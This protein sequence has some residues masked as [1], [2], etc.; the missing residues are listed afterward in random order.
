[1]AQYLIQ[2]ALWWVETANLDGIRLD[3]F[4]YVSRAYWQNFHAAL[5]SVYPHLTT[6]GEVFHR[7]PEVTS[8]FAGGIKHQGIDTGLDTPFDFPAYFALRDTL[9]HDKPMTEL[10]EVLRQDDLYPHPE[11][12]VP[13]IGNHDT[14]RFLTDA[15]GSEPRLKLALGLL[16]VLRGMPQIYSGDEIGMSGGADPDNRHDFPGGFATDPHNAFTE[17]GRT[18]QQQEIFT[19]TA[20]LLALRFAHIAL[21]SGMEQNLFADEDGFA[22]VRAIHR[23]GCLQDR[24]ADRARAPMLIIVN[25][26]AKTKTIDLPMAETALGGCTTFTPQAPAAD[27]R[28]MIQNGTLHIEEPAETMSIYEVH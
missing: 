5:D 22:F 14:T 17:A 13:F 12:L 23:G 9:A 27:N 7:D 6:V 4:P 8:Y 18:P 10:A 28:P 25:K 20:S 11:R 26:S 3:T 2:N 16:A 1:V 19:W 24:S 21:Q 15:N